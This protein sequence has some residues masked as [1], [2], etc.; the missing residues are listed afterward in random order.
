MV[1]V[2]II[3]HYIKFSFHKG[4]YSMTKYDT[5]IIGSGLGAMTTGAL[6]ARQN[7]KKV[8]VLEK[9]NQIGG[10]ATTFQMDTFNF[11][12]SLH[13]LGGLDVS[14]KGRFK[15]ILQNTG[16]FDT[17]DLFKPKYL[18]ETDI[19]DGK[20]Y[21]FP[22]GDL[23]AIKKQMYN[24]FPKDTLGIWYFFFWMKFIGKHIN[25]MQAG[26]AFYEGMIMAT[27]PVT[28]PSLFLAPMIK[29]RHAFCFVK[30]PKTRQVLNHFMEYYGHDEKTLNIQF[31]MT[32]N[33]GYYQGTGTYVRNGG[34]QLALE[35][36]KQI[37][38]KGGC[39]LTETPVDTI[40]MKKNKAIGVQSGKDTYYITD[41]GHVVSGISPHITYGTLLKS[42]KPAKKQFAKVQK[43]TT[44]MSA[45]VMYIGLDCPIDSLTDRF[46]DTYEISYHGENSY[47]P[48]NFEY[49]KT[50][51][52]VPCAITF[53]PN[54]KDDVKNT[55]NIFC[56]DMYKKW[57][58]LT[59]EQYKQNKKLLEEKMLNTLEH[60]IPNISKHI[61]I[62]TLATPITMESYTHN[63]DGALY[64]FDQSTKQAG[65]YNRFKLKSKVVSNLLFASAWTF[66]GGG[67][68]GVIR[69]GE[70]VY[71]L[72][73]GFFLKRRLSICFWAVIIAILS[74]V[75]TTLVL[76]RLL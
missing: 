58:D 1:L 65:L 20:I 62:K 7:N 39:V 18:Y 59:E 21:K 42:Y 32:G 75:G 71:Q 51:D 2:H 76:T 15:K 43:L 23:N 63:P 48:E 38:A 52:K 22:N 37:E 56:T 8:L 25:R 45:S 24:Y 67:Y 50:D 27:A 54:G 16:V 44:S 36:Q 61:K 64:G 66:P 40:L 19:G 49:L 33:Y 14:Y 28:A 3:A 5:I 34:Q 74:F 41:K 68:E 12:V 72:I 26:G 11:D 35:M 29:Y 57:A 17:L 31:P 6:L 69:S 4:A 60:L 13:M 47:N 70:M 73:T 55:V 46:K 30:S 10:Y 9:H 53:H